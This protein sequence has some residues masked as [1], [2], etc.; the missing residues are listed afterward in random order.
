[1]QA[2]DHYGEGSE[3]GQVKIVINACFGG[4]GLSPKAVKRWAELKGRECYF[5][6]PVGSPG[7]DEQIRCTMEEAEESRMWW[8]AFDIPDTSAIMI[9]ME[10]WS[11]LPLADRAAH[12]A[13]YREHCLDDRAIPRDDPALVRVVEE[14]GPKA[15]GMC[16]KL[17]VVE[18]PDGV[19]WQIEEY[20]GNE[21]IAEKH[22][23]W[24]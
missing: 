15:G 9:S 14:L 2:R 21:H 18:V 8:S 17:R 12:N 3:G 4:F 13:K 23:T 24:P 22:R 16:A 7:I 20:D 6:R 1:M 10:N 11:K 5:Y 19:E